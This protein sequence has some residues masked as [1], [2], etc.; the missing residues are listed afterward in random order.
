PPSVTPLALE[1]EKDIDPSN[2]KELIFHIRGGFPSSATLVVQSRAFSPLHY[3]EVPPH[4]HSLNITLSTQ[5]GLDAHT[6]SLGDITTSDEL[7]PSNLEFW[8]FCTSGAA[9]DYAIR[10]W[11]PANYVT[12]TGSAN[13]G[14]VLW[15]MT[16]TSG[17]RVTGSKHHHGIA[18]GQSTS[19][20]GA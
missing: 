3:T 7:D 11:Q 10:L 20:A 19:P 2:P 14:D 6:H 8:S 5:P 1:G 16:S 17:F 15:N 18:A 9:G 4:D 13:W 12:S